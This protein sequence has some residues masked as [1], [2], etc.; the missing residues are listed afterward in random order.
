MNDFEKKEK[1]LGDAMVR[2]LVN[3]NDVHY[4]LYGGYLGFVTTD[5]EKA[6]TWMSQG[7]KLYCKMLDGLMI[8]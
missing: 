5:A 2:S 6:K 8:L 4:V 1:L 7:Y 3:P